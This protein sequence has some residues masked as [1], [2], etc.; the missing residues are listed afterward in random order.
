MDKK[1]K[2]DFWA[3]FEDIERLKRVPR[4]GWW[5]YGIADP[6]S[7]ADHSFCVAFLSY[8]IAT[9]INESTEVKLDVGK[10]MKMALIHELG[11]SRIGDLQLE[12]RRFLGEDH[13]RNAESRVVEEITSGLGELGSEIRELFVE[14]SKRETPEAKLVHVA[15]KME[16]LFQAS[17][18][19]KYGYRNL[20]SI[21]WGQRN[22]LETF[23]HPLIEEL[24]KI[25]QEKGPNDG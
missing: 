22:L 5:Y 19:Q 14:Y 15:D 23:P 4:S 3:F 20:E 24:L 17:L 9:L 16:L 18:Y 2:G 25:I 1:G 8:L 21:F 12:A 11:E 7:V 10:V 6:E 13:V